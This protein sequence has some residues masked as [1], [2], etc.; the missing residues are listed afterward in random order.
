MRVTLL[1]IAKRVGVAKTTVSMALR[2]SH[3]VSYARRQEIQRVAKEMG[4]VPDPF[5]S[6]LAAHSRERVSAKNHG[7]LAWFNHWKDPKRLLQFKE[8]KGYLRGA[9]EA[10]TRFGY[11][12]DEVRWE[13][14]C[15]P[16]RFE[17]ILLAR[18]IEGILVPPHNEL[19]DWQDFDW[20]KFSVI[21][22]GM[23]VQ[24]P[25][26][27]LVTSDAYRAT[28]MAIKQIHDYGYRRIGLT[29]NEEYNQRLGGNFLSGYFYA[30]TLLKLKKLPPP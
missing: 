16:K 29:V 23:S 1:D 20:T 4:Y 7:V 3:Q 18:G 19:L 9:R 24:N 22:F 14:D 26:S 28:V 13:R 12:V 25:D 17:R 5:L 11:R 6:G 8:F 21:R 15:S 27:N 2:E 30:Q 10:A